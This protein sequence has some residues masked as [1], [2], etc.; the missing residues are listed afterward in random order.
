MKRK[1]KAAYSSRQKLSETSPEYKFGTRLKKEM[2]KKGMSQSDLAQ[3]MNVSES[4]VKDWCQH[5]T[6]P[7]EMN[8]GEL[9]RIFAPCSM[10]YFH[11]NIDEP[12]YDI[13]F[14]MKYTGL[15]E[16]AVQYLYD[17][18]HIDGD[19]S[20]GERQRQK[21]LYRDMFGMEIRLSYSDILDVLL[22]DDSGFTEV[23]LCI[24]EADASLLEYMEHKKAF[25]SN[26][27]LRD[28]ESV[29]NYTNT[30]ALSEMRF[31]DAKA[32]AVDRFRDCIYEL[33][34][35]SPEGFIHENKEPPASG[36]DTDGLSLN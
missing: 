36:I 29:T 32:A 15:S 20:P 27:D 7:N 13:Q 21:Q 33:L 24:A 4:A 8:L 11:G 14:V 22:S 3:M 23:L 5:Y 16:T 6:F 17:F 9:C 35:S 26:G 10:D 25:N 12:N 1:E 19:I 18:A 30:Q 34:P 28:L 2:K 31:R